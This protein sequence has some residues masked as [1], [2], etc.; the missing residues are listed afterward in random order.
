MATSQVGRMKLA[1]TDITALLPLVPLMYGAFGD[2]VQF[3]R[4]KTPLLLILFVAI[5]IT[6]KPSNKHRLITF[7]PS[8]RPNWLH[9]Q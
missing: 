8:K 3:S 6:E 9:R 5:R 7:L 1:L 4:I 2:E